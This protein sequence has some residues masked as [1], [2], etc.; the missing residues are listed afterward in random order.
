MSPTSRLIA[1][2]Q[3]I[4]KDRYATPQKGSTISSSGYS[5]VPTSQDKRAKVVSSQKY[6]K[7]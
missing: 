2:K 7:P 5:S 3:Q 4:V 1:H 6:V